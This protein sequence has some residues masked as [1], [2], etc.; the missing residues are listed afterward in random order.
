MRLASR[1]LPIVAFV[2]VAMVAPATASA[3]S[4]NGFHTEHFRCYTV[5]GPKISADL[6]F[7]QVT[8]SDQFEQIQT[9]KV[10]R[11]V[12]L[13]NPVE[14]CPDEYGC[15]PVYNPIDHLVCYR[16]SEPPANFVGN[17]IGKIV[18]IENQF[19]DEQL[20]IVKR[21]N[22]LCVPSFKCDLVNGTPQCAVV[23]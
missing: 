14:K 22:L 20:G 2:L 18:E 9:T 17:A 8:L 15:E 4:T 11:P 10:L 7:N 3:P 12:L 1:S 23:W 19:E 13:C 21:S 5:E 6:K 16:T